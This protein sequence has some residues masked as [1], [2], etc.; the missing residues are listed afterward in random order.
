MALT[1]KQEI[2]KIVKHSA[3]PVTIEFVRTCVNTTWSNAKAL[4]LELV[5]EGKIKSLQT[6]H[7]RIFGPR[8]KEWKE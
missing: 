7:G 2:L 6:T 1:L 5:I 8:N 4:L 3:K